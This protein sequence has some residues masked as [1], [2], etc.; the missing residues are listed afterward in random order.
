M[1][2][3]QRPKLVGQTSRDGE[4]LRKSLS[5]E[6]KNSPEP[7]FFS[8]ES[9]SLF[10]RFSTGAQALFFLLFLPFSAEKKKRQKVGEKAWRG[11]MAT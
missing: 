2:V 10:S 6:L 5:P 1:G 3:K 4:P 8:L 9:L 11:R 7:P